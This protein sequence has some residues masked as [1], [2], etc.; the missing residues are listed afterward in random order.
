MSDGNGQLPIEITGNA[1]S[2]V[3]A[4]QQTNAA[5]DSTKIKLAELTPAQKANLVSTQDLSGATKV[6]AEEMKRMEAPTR[7]LRTLFGQVGQASKG[8]QFGLS[9]LSGVMLGSLT[10]GIYAVVAGIEALVEHFKEQKAV[11]SKRPKQPCTSGQMP[12]KGMRMPERRLRITP[13]LC[14]GL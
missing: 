4:V 14:A 7:E 9:A 8:L 10:F 13:R 1:S 2:L 12:S 6:A 5:L 11:A 3:A